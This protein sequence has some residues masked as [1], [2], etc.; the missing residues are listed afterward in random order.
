[1]TIKSTHVY[2]RSQCHSYTL[3]TTTCSYTVHCK[4]E[5]A[6]DY[7][8]TSV[9]EATRMG[10]LHA[11]FVSQGS[12]VF[13]HGEIA[14]LSGILLELVW[15]W[16]PH[17]CALAS[18]TNYCMKFLRIVAVSPHSQLLV[19]WWML[20][21]QVLQQLLALH[22]LSVHVVCKGG[23]RISQHLHVNS[24]VARINSLMQL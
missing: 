16:P 22:R 12:R 13:V 23:W 19:R 11:L 20:M 24:G 5:T 18:T 2:F 6:I 1:M 9:G 3:S 14:I 8:P 7:A 21:D 10:D 4:S 17:G 15:P